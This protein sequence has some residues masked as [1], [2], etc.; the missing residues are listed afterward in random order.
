MVYRKTKKTKSLAPKTARAVSRIANRAIARTHEVKYSLYQQP[1]FAVLANG[2]NMYNATAAIVRGTEDI[3]HRVGDRIKLIG[4]R[5][6]FTIKE[7]IGNDACQ[8]ARIMIFQWHPNSVPTPDMLL[9]NFSATAGPLTMSAM[10]NYDRRQDYTVLYDKVLTMTDT[11]DSCIIY[12]KKFLKR[13][14]QQIQYSAGGITSTNAI[15]VIAIS[16]DPS[17]TNANS[18]FMSYTLSQYYTDA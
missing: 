11:A 5:F 17:Y 8:M 3:N 1:E 9:Q 16:D 14:R 2:T 4:L 18:P 12:R 13:M 7:R 10:H 15:W 6:A